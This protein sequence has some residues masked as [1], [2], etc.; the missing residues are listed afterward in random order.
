MPEPHHLHLAEMR[1]SIAAREMLVTD[2]RAWLE[3]IRV[4][5]F[6]VP[7]EQLRELAKLTD[8]ARRLRQCY[9]DPTR[10]HLAEMRA[11]RK[12]QP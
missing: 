4:A 10:R 5:A 9:P 2:T 1:A 3:S 12:E 8:E 7:R 6:K 11:S